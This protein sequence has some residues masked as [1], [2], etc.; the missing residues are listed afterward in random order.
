[1]SF[2]ISGIVVAGA[3]VA[4]AAMSA[5]AAK[6]AAGA[7]A[8]AARNAANLSQD[9]WEKTV[10]LQEP[11]RLAGVEA[12]NKLVPL[13]TEYTPFGMAQFQADPGYGFRMSEGMKQLERSASA[14]GGLLSG[15]TLKGIQRFGQDMA[16]QEYQNAF[17]RY[18]AERAS[19]LQPLQ[20][21]AGMGQTTANQ[22]GNSGQMMAQQ[23]G[24]LGMQGANARASGY[25][26]Q[27]NAL[28]SALNTGLNYYQNQQMM[29][30]FKPTPTNPSASMY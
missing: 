9:Q 22:L 24:E 10:E 15:G 21:L 28:N 7:Q 16:S 4:S 25:V 3:T 12:L 2:V 19:R 5:N 8:D 1:M 26:G 6:K 30:Q 18:Q 17:N 14:R 29:N 20:S 13:S 23:V 27:S 11:W